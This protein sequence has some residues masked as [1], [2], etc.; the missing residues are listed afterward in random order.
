MSEYAPNWNELEEK[1]KYVYELNGNEIATTTE[2]DSLLD[3]GYTKHARPIRLVDGAWYALTVNDS[4]F[5]FNTVGQWDRNKKHFAINID[6]VWTLD[7]VT[8]HNR[9]PDEMWEEQIC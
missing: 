1:F 7:R 6:V 9:I 2:F 3:T 8:I 4:G 5:R